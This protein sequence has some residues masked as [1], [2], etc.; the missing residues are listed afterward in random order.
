MRFWIG[1]TNLTGNGWH[2]IDDDSNIAYFDWA[3]GEPRNSTHE[4][5]VTID[6][7]GLWYNEE[8]FKNF[9]F[10]CEM[11][12]VFVNLDGQE[13][14]IPYPSV[15]AME[16]WITRDTVNVPGNYLSGNSSDWSVVRLLTESTNA[17]FMTL[18]PSNFFVGL[19][20][21]PTWYSSQ[22]VYYKTFS[23]CTYNG[24]IF[25]PIDTFAQS[26][27]IYLNGKNAGNNG[28]SSTLYVQLPNG[29]MSNLATAVLTDTANG[30]GVYDVRRPCDA[31][32]EM[33]EPSVPYCFRAFQ[34]NQPWNAARQ[35]CTDT[36]GF[37]VDDMNQAKDDFISE[38]T[39]DN[40][41]WI[42]LNSLNGT[43]TW[44][45]GVGQTGDSY[46]GS[47]FGP[48]ANGDSNIDPNNPCVYRGK[49]I[50]KDMNDNDV[51]AGRWQTSF[52]SPGEF[53]DPSTDKVF[54]LQYAQIT[55]AYDGTLYNITTYEHGMDWRYEYVSRNFTYPNGCNADNKLA[56]IHIGK[57]KFGLLFQRMN[58]DYYVTCIT[59]VNT[60]FS[61]D[62]K[63]FIVVIETTTQN[64]EAVQK[65]GADLTAIL[66]NVTS[67]TSSNWFSQYILV[68]FD[69]NGVISKRS[70]TNVNDFVNLYNTNTGTLSNNNNCNLP[71]F[72][73]IATVATSDL[74]SQ[75]IMY[76]V[77]T[78]GSSSDDTTNSIYTAFNNATTTDIM[79]NYVLIVSDSCSNEVTTGSSMYISNL[80][81]ATGGNT[82]LI[83][84]GEI[85]NF[86]GAHLPTLYNGRVLGTPSLINQSH[87]CTEMVFYFPIDRDVPDGTIV[88]KSFYADKNLFFYSFPSAG[89]GIYALS[90]SDPGICMV[91][92]RIQGGSEIY[93]NFITVPSING[94]V[95]SNLD[96]SS[97]VPNIGQNLLVIHMPDER[98][99]VQYAQFWPTR[100]A[101][102]VIQYV[103]LYRR[104]NC[105]YEWY[106][107]PF[108]CDEDG[109]FITVF[110][111]GSR[112]APW[113]RQFYTKCSGYN[114]SSTLAPPT[115][116]PPPT[117]PTPSPTTTSPTTTTTENTGTTAPPPISTTTSA[118]QTT[119]TSKYYPV[120][121]D[122]VF[123]IDISQ[124]KG[125]QISI[126]TVYGDNNGFASIISNFN[127]IT[128]Y[129]SLKNALDNG[130]PQ[131]A[132]TS[133]IGQ[134]ALIQALKLVMSPQF[135]GAGYRNTTQNHLIVYITTTST[136]IQPS[137]DQ[138]FLILSSGDYKIV[139]IS[140]QGDGSNLNTLQQLVGNNAGCVLTSSNQ[141]DYTGAFAQYFADK[142][143]NAN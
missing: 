62:G 69:S 25:A 16:L 135:K 82:Y 13:N 7:N 43:W 20:L 113:A 70:A 114:G 117:G 120:N 136:P 88:P 65:F 106:S 112:G 11:E 19:K 23:D 109:Y 67:A 2:N 22:L 96:N 12:I 36:G 8:C 107:D 93:P 126:L 140:Y 24:S 48:W 50:P 97:P 99:E 38:Y 83:D 33:S 58:F 60:T 78:G 131:D 105:F 28:A 26:I 32:W 100:S 27:Q 56:V 133:G 123:I 72:A 75:S 46:N 76:L 9:P 74:P 81:A 137:I 138:A 41:T 39:M 51:P 6:M 40:A 125:V 42:G 10:I 87:Q 77:T 119:T 128:D 103:Q 49:F 92:V 21:I 90:I 85:S 64:Q 95:A 79:I 54:I 68:T 4:Q 57:D 5:C 17:K 35:I 30:F 89:Q 34:S 47:I 110:G 53:E 142:I 127:G 130:Y 31:G 45:R 101:L 132:S 66:N 129:N 61:N 104:F 52:S 37:L 1:V 122:V 118:G 84:A 91:Q 80:A 94:S 115:T 121:A 59:P 134:S 116:Q 139:A 15:T 18:Q 44:D 29:T 143:F 71:I 55:D 141:G 86:A 111:I 73:T 63:A 124:A 102:E 3:F 14:T 98:V 108:T